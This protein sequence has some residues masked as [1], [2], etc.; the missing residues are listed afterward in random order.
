MKPSTKLRPAQLNEHIDPMYAAL[1]DHSKYR[2]PGK[3]E[4][5]MLDFAEGDDGLSIEI[6]NRGY[7]AIL[8]DLGGMT[9]FLSCCISIVIYS[10]E[11]HLFFGGAL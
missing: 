1:E 6:K 10:E 2:E 4:K 8:R 3:I 5:F 9:V 11:I 7:K